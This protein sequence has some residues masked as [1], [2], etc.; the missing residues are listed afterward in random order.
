MFPLPTRW[1]LTSRVSRIFFLSIVCI[2]LCTP[3]LQVTAQR[4]KRK[5]PV[6]RKA[7]TATKT[8]APRLVG[9]QNFAP[10]TGC[11]P[12]A[13]IIDI[14]PDTP[15]IHQALKN[16]VAQDN[17]IVRL[18]P[19]LD[20]DFTGLPDNFFPIEFGRCVT[21]MSVS[22]FE[23]PA[24]SSVR[25]PRRRSAQ[26]RS[27]A[28]SVFGDVVG[29][30][31]GLEVERPP[32]IGSART[33]KS[34][35]PVLRYGTSHAVAEGEKPRENFFEIRCFPDPDK[36]NDGVRISG[37]RLYGPSFDAQTT[38]EVG[39]R[40]ISCLDIEVSNMEVAGWGGVGIEVDN[41]NPQRITQETPVRIFN[42][43]IHH[44][45]H[46]NKDSHASGYGIN[47]AI[48]A[49]AQITHNVFD[50][51]RHAIAAKG[52]S[53]GYDARFNL[54]LKGGGIHGTW[55]NET[56]HQFDVHGDKD[57]GFLGIGG[58]ADC[59]HAGDTFSIVS[60]AFQYDN[61][62]AI[63]LRGKPRTKAYIALN[64]FPHEGLEDDW[65]DD[66]IHLQTTK[67]VEIGGGNKIETDSYAKYQACDF[68][69]DGLDDLFLATGASWWFSSQGRYPW[70]FIS[71]K[72]EKWDE[73]KVG[74]F[75]DD[76]V[77]DVLTERGG[78]W[79]FSSGGRG[80]W[81]TLGHFGAPLSEITLGRFDNSP[82]DRPGVR[83]TPHVF[84]RHLDGQWWI[85]NLYD[86]RRGDPVAW[87]DVGSSGFPM[88]KLAFGDFKGDGILDVLAVV[89]GH[90]QVSDDA[91]GPWR[92][93]NRDLK[94]DVSKVFIANM[95][96]DDTIDDVLGLTSETRKI[97]VNGVTQDQ[98]WVVWM[99]SR[100]GDQ[101][102]KPV[103]SQ[104]YLLPKATNLVG[105]VGRFAVA[106]RGTAMWIDVGRTG[107]F[108]SLAE[109]QAGRPGTWAG[110]FSY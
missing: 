103:Y 39:I 50:F 34:P 64:I 75:D 87:R 63:S 95:D 20:L 84:K 67:N 88:N 109:S 68:D 54:V 72:T 32:V 101:P 92:D 62:N 79:L 59:G 15:N 76:L 40:I 24:T 78:L 38:D 52:I 73:V 99:R 23:T 48:N 3:E 61:D 83:R 106:P 7:T 56:T 102:W 55:Y 33:P 22:S 45:Q 28:S 53:G 60:N 42:N 51:N 110:E 96:S 71:A 80:D 26:R 5:P 69:A 65:G 16:A 58:D 8:T 97:Q 17:T 10:A 93:L 21:L 9:T 31:G 13:T 98:T 105:F 86:Y 94:Y 4:R 37:F 90:W 27:S 36:K 89:S 1:L 25:A 77:C 29:P 46:P 91:R 81:Q 85:A 70:S 108:F 57:C 2:L 44:N 11:A 19:D 100:N 107:K 43:Y 74:Y 35:G 49:W 30:L 41:A 82:P 18:S 47:V 12:T 6:G 66:A 104:R 14:K